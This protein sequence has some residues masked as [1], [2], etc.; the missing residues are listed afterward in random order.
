[1]CD[2]VL[3]CGKMCCYVCVCVSMCDDEFLFV[4]MCFYVF[5]CVRMCFLCV[6]MSF[7]V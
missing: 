7:Y 1:M 5:Q 3:L 4:T 6:T 2:N